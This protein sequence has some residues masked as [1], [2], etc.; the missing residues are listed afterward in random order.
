MSRTVGEDEEQ[1]D[2][3]NDS[4]DWHQVVRIPR[5]NHN[6]H[7]HEDHDEYVDQTQYGPD[8]KVW[9]LFISVWR[10]PSA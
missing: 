7:D 5:Y 6:V 2:I 4:G 1:Y 9:H 3:D 10:F 8:G